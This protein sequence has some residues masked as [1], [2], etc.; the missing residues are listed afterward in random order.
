M[1][2]EMLYDFL[3]GDFL[4]SFPSL[5]VELSAELSAELSDDLSG[6]KNQYK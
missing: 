6:V 5:L 3:S 2:Q 4:P 1:S